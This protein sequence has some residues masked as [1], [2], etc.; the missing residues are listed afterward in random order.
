MVDNYVLEEGYIRP[1]EE[2]SYELRIWMDES[3]GNDQMEKYFE[4]VVS[5]SSIAAS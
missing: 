3:A 5:I 1:D 4:A 2:Y